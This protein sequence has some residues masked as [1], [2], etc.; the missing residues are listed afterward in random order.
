ML[1][2]DE[3]R[4]TAM[5]PYYSARGDVR[6]ALATLRLD[7]F[8]DTASSPASCSVVRLGI[9]PDAHHRQGLITILALCQGKA[10]DVKSSMF[11]VLFVLCTYED[12]AGICKLCGPLKHMVHVELTWHFRHYPEASSG[13]HPASSSSSSSVSSLFRTACP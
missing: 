6:I 10:H 4:G 8:V 3:P 7:I 1:N 9:L 5:R 13:Q 2:G 12:C 11:L